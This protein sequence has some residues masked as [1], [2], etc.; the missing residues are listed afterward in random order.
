MEK[1]TDP[2]NQ[3]SSPKLFRAVPYDQLNSLYSTDN[4]PRYQHLVQTFVSR[5]GR[6][7]E[8]IARAPGRVDIIGGHLDYNHYP[9]L[10]IAL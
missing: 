5:H 4:N 2:T 7:P 9:V 10:P 3:E 1:P 6:K 8:F